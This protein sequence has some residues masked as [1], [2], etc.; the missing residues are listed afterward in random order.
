MQVLNIRCFSNL[1][2]LSQD[3]IR[4]VK[5]GTSQQSEDDKRRE[6]PGGIQTQ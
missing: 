1:E 5:G 2:K 4:K 6:R 3:Q